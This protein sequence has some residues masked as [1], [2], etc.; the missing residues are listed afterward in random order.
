MTAYSPAHAVA[1]DEAELRRIVSPDARMEKL[2]GGFGFIEGPVWS[3]AGGGSLIFSDIPRNEMKRWTPA[4]AVATYRT[5][6]GNANGNTRDREGRLITCEHSGRR[7]SIESRRGGSRPWSTPTRGGAST[8]PTT[9]WSARTAASG[10]PTPPTA[11]ASTPRTRSKSITTSSASTP[12]AATCAPWS[13]D[14]HRPNGLCFSPDERRL[15]IA[16]AGDPA[17]R[18]RL[19]RRGRRRPHRGAG[20]LHHQPRHPGRDALRHGGAPLLQRR[21]RHPHLH[22]RGRPDRQ[23]HHPGRPGALR[24]LPHRPRSPG[25]PLLRRPGRDAPSTSPPAPPSTPSPSSPAAPSCIDGLLLAG[26]APCGRRTPLSCT[27]TAGAP[28][29]TRARPLRAGDQASATEPSSCRGVRSSFA[30]G[31]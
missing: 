1:F 5:P 13:D 18:P 27:E 9:S 7:V 8:P 30:W 6:S 14:F 29:V 21:G 23:A 4:G 31:G 16:D 11:S 19:R 3:S 24:S 20:L 28:T 17:P 12:A 15:Y 26:S 2:A 10:S 22:R 25:Q